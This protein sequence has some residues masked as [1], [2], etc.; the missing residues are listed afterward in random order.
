MAR[1]RPTLRLRWRWL[2]VLILL[3]FLLSAAVLVWQNRVSAASLSAAPSIQF[4]HQKH[5]AAGVPCLFCHPGALN[6]AVASIPSVQKCMGCHNNVQV[7]STAGQRVV[8]Q[9]TAAWQAGQ[10]LVWTRVVNL[11]DFVHFTHAPHIAAGKN[12]ETCHGDVGQ[13]T[14][15]ALAYRINMGFCLDQCHRHQN[16]ALRERLMSCATCHQ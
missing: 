13:M 8:N 10:P 4:N 9:L 6:G 3:L 14:T 12:C 15:T 7:T 16:A 11:P 1:A 5:V 2:V